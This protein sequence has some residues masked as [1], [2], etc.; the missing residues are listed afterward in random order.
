M[1]NRTMSMRCVKRSRMAHAKAQTRLQ[2][3][4]LKSYNCYAYTKLKPLFI[5]L[6][7]KIGGYV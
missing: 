7:A 2:R 1:T 3:I 6:S 4:I 5:S